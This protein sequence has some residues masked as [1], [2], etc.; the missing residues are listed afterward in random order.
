MKINSKNQDGFAHIEKLLLAV[1]VLMI[2]G[3]GWYVFRAQSQANK[4]LNSADASANSI[5]SSRKSKQTSPTPSPN[6]N[7]KKV[8]PAAP[9][10][11][12][13]PFVSTAPSLQTTTPTVVNNYITINEWNIRSKPNGTITIM[14]AHDS[15]DKNHRSIFFGS[16]QLA[17]K[18][19]A[20]KAVFYPAGYIVRYKADEHVYDDKGNDTSKAA[21]TYA[22]ELKDQ[23]VKQIGDYY[24]FYR[25]PVAKCSE[26]KEIQ[27]LQD[28]S[29]QAVKAFFDSLEAAQ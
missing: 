12:P 16:T 6:P 29:A 5:I 23:T 1:I 20:C 3:V 7:V 18:N 25:G 8:T 11:A 28:Q 13:A 10:P 24:Y 17:S 22:V 2:A 15:N 9:A 19:N 14:Y 27:D 21:K 26:L 4:N